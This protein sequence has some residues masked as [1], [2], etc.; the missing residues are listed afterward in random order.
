MPILEL[1]EPDVHLSQGDLLKDLQMHIS[2]S[3]GH[4]KLIKQSLGLVLSRT[5]VIENKKKIIVAPVDVLQVPFSKEKDK[6]GSRARFFEHIINTLASV[7]D[8]DGMPDRFYLGNIPRVQNRLAARLDEL[9]T[10]ELPINLNEWTSARRVARLTKEFLVALPVRLYGAFAKA[11]FS[12][13]SWLP[14]VDLEL[15]VH[16][17]KAAQAELAA[18]VEDERCELNLQQDSDLRRR[19]KY[20][21]KVEETQSEI[22]ALRE[23]LAPYEAELNARTAQMTPSTPV[24]HM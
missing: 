23:K 16:A 5:C 21:K 10:I 15:L 9:C 1:P 3:D 13:Y 2:S 11:G 22:N 20:E 24:P 19:T 6:E 8:G 4:P 14:Q 12:D 17:G 18:Q 7:R